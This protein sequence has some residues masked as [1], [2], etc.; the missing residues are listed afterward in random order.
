MANQECK[1][2]EFAK[3]E[4]RHLNR[5]R[6]EPAAAST[7]CP[8]GVPPTRCLRDLTCSALLL[9]SITSN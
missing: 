3:S 6:H 9:N 2:D 4:C 1:S 8:H 7:V 5:R